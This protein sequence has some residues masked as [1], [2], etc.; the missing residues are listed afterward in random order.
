MLVGAIMAIASVAG[1]ELLALLFPDTRPFYLATIL[2]VYGVGTFLGFRLQ[3]TFT[4]SRVPATNRHA[5]LIG[6]YAV[7][8]SVG[9]LTAALAYFFRYDLGFE[10]IFA[11]MGAAAAYACS[12]LITSVASYSLSARFV[13]PRQ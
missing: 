12:T 1:R 3:E 13:F 4:F 7:A 11:P 8:V 9:I 5:S 2:I 6:F 10:N